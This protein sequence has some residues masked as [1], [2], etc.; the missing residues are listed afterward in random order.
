ML[1]RSGSLLAAATFCVLSAAQPAL[2]LPNIPGRPDFSP[3][4]PIDGRPIDPLPDREPINPPP[5]GVPAAATLKVP[6]SALAQAIDIAP[7]PAAPLPPDARLPMPSAMGVR[8]DPGTPNPA[9]GQ[10][11]VVE[12]GPEAPDGVLTRVTAT[13]TLADGSTAVSGQPAR[14][15]EVIPAGDY[16][17]DVD[18]DNP[19]PQ[20]ARVTANGA[21]TPNAKVSKVLISE[22]A[23]NNDWCKG[24]AG[25]VTFNGSMSIDG[26]LKMNVK[27]RPFN[28]SVKA[29]LELSEKAKAE[30]AA[31][32]SLTCQHTS[33][34]KQLG[35]VVF[36]IYGLTFVA[37]IDVTF[38]GKVVL[39]AAGTLTYQ[40][41]TTGWV[42]LEKKEF[43]SP[44]LTHDFNTTS[45]F[46]KSF[47]GK[48]Q[49]EGGI[50]PAVGISFYG[51]SAAV[52]VRGYV[53]VTGDSTRAPQ[54]EAYAG[55]QGRARLGQKTWYTF[56]DKKWILGSGVSIAT[57]ALPSAIEGVAYSTKLIAS[58]GQAPYSFT[59]SGI[60]P[61]PAWL[62]IGADGTLSGTP[63]ASDR[64]TTIRV[65]V[66]DATGEYA[67]R[68]LEL[69]ISPSQTIPK[70]QPT[71]TRLPI[72]DPDL[73]PPCNPIPGRPC[74]VVR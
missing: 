20:S 25:P 9:I 30:L 74:N 17:F 6:S 22:Q 14:V 56:A 29:T 37:F 51:L 28:S 19:A 3:G 26:D 7:E 68:D 65:R 49:L 63:G 44:K 34:P 2:A 38:D 32:A 72:P 47:T 61:P 18:L 59:W 58:G 21:A 31:K 16:D 55:L 66:V 33:A 53:G 27:I 11:L 43:R 71:R 8:L 64:T 36:N 70:P 40:Q 45:S 62:T 50:T 5:A 52:G 10:I 1:A 57:T 13:T 73:P 60:A 48:A 15:D 35:Y 12:P 41:Q 4:R 67:D 54:W 69:R 46:T 24:T 23:F 39:D 42:A